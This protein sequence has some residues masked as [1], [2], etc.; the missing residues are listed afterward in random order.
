MKSTEA[1]AALGALAHPTRLELFRRLIRHR[2]WT[3]V[4]GMLSI[5]V[6]AMYGMYHNL[7]VVNGF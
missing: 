7:V 4:I 1:L 5:F 3:Q 6:T 2:F